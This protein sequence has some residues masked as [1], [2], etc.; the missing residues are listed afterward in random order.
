MGKPHT[1]T[2]KVHLAREV[3]REDKAI[4]QLAAERGIHPNQLSNVSNGV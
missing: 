4:N 1:A 3:L 2:F